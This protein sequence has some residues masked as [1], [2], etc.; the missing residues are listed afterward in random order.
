VIAMKQLGHYA[1]TYDAN[2][3]ISRDRQNVSVLNRLI[4]PE[5]EVNF[6][7]VKHCCREMGFKSIR[8]S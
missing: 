3:N 2:S 4:P 7:S 1:P 6:E 5:S 8:L